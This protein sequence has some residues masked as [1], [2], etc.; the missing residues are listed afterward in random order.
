[1]PSEVETPNEGCNHSFDLH[2][3][4]R[5][6]YDS[7]AEIGEMI[8]AARA[9]GLSGF[10]LTDHDTSE[11][12]EVLETLGLLDPAGEPVD[13][14]LIVPGQ[15]VTTAQGHLL[16]LG[17]KLPRLKGIDAAEAIAIIHELGGLAVAPH[18]YDTFRLGI[19]RKHLDHLPL[20]ALEVFNAASTLKRYN[21]WAKQYAEARS[22]PMMAAS[23]AHS[24]EAIGTA[25]TTFHLHKLSLASVLRSLRA[26]HGVLTENYLS[27][28]AALKKTWGNW[29][30]LGHKNK[31]LS[32]AGNRSL[33]F[34][35]IKNQNTH[36]QS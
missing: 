2:C 25:R 36:P 35:Q 20:D 19:R 9:A 13:G 6:S 24:P 3:H 29:I 26:G 30:R 23:D 18:P 16:G 31:D 5:Y 11:G 22:L 33:K 12:C 8:A 28:R 14:F 4:S 17:V 10:A 1:M 27:T 32:L 34:G 7:R 21:R 15:E